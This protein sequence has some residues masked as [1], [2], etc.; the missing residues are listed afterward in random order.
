LLRHT[1]K[2][3]FR[4]LHIASGFFF[5][6]VALFSLI[7]LSENLLA[8]SLEAAMALVVMVV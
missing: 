7:N 1:H 4:P 2:G 8:S 5:K 6:S 3:H